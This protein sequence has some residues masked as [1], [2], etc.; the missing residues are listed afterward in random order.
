MTEAGGERGEFIR[1]PTP[2]WATAILHGGQ[3][4][5]V[6]AIQASRVSGRA[7]RRQS[8][9]RA[10]TQLERYALGRPGEQSAQRRAPARYDPGRI[11]ARI[12]APLRRPLSCDNS[13]S[14]RP[15]RRPCSFVLSCE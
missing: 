10:P 13:S 12:M 5:P 3:S 2:G 11:P 8:V 4:V 1:L 14:V 7:D 9:P 15:F 6:W